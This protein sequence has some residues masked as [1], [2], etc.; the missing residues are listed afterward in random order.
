MHFFLSELYTNVKMSYSRQWFENVQMHL[1]TFTTA[2]RE[3]MHLCI[4]LNGHT[5]ATV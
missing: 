5:S 3:L 2:H 1:C 4:T